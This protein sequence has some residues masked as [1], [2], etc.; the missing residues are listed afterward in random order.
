MLV[1]YEGRQYIVV[2]MCLYEYTNLPNEKNDALC[3]SVNSNAFKWINISE[4]SILDGRLPSGMCIYR[5]RIERTGQNES[6]L[7][8]AA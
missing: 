3:L 8:T 7:E 4:A 2:T 6:Y 5:K 1:E